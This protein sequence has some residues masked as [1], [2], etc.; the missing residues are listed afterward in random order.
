MRVNDNL[1]NESRHIREVLA[2][3]GAT[4]HSAQVLEHALVNAL[5]YVQLIPAHAATP[6]LSKDAWAVL[7]DSFTDKQFESTLGRLIANLR[8]AVS[9]PS[10]LEGLFTHGL[11]IRNQLAHSYFRDRTV[12]FMTPEG[13]DIMIGELEKMGE[14]L[15]EAEQRLAEAMRPIRARYGM[16]DEMLER[17]YQSKLAELGIQR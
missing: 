12:E 6:P 17:E 5:I 9:I 8:R 14:I 16:T 15:D 11:K 13:R 3:F 10:D 2:Y 1:D 7:F 4:M